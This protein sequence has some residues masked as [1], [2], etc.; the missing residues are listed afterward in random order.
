MFRN[1]LKGIVVLVDSFRGLRWVGKRLE[2]YPV[3][4]EQ[5]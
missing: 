1:F 3:V 4:A 5:A 2:G